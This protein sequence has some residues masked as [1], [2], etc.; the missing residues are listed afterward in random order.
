[1]A[2][3]SADPKE[4]TKEV[5]AKGEESASSD[6]ASKPESKDDSESAASDGDASADASANSTD[7]AD[8][9]DAD[10]AE[11]ADDDGDDAAP[12]REALD[13]AAAAAKALDEASAAVSK[14]TSAEKARSGKSGS[15]GGKRTKKPVARKSGVS[16]R[17]VILFGGLVVLL[18]A[19][20]GVLGSRNNG[21]P[22]NAP[23]WKL[24]EPVD[25]EITLVA[26]DANDLNCAMEGEIGGLHCGFT[27]GNARNAA[28]RGSRD[29]AK[30]L[31]PYSTTNRQ[32]FLAAGLWMQPELKDAAEL[33]KRVKAMQNPRFAVNCKFTPRG[34]A[35]SAKVQWK[36][37][38]DWGPG[39]G[40]YVGDVKD[41]KLA[42]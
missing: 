9:E 12:G 10:S 32:N 31:Q 4:E 7:D 8:E 30:L 38:A 25:V 17:N 14:M 11:S 21:G 15:K 3:E 16:A 29:D 19:A 20:F 28:A 5:P 23:R 40:W 2:S 34:K 24:N 18:L 1:M 13:K 6:D 35:K 26:T 22:Q 39:D 27:S 36:A 41:C 37:G 42:K 33:D